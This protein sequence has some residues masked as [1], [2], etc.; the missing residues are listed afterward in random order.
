MFNVINGLRHE[1]VKRIFQSRNNVPYNLRQRPQFRTLY[2]QFACTVRFLGNPEK[3]LSS[4][5]LHP[6]LADYASGIFIRRLSLLALA[7]FWAMLI[8]F[9]VLLLVINIFINILVNIQV[10][11]LP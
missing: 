10:L 4:G 3:Q 9:F 7:L 5:K 8:L 1:I 11:L 2:M 6:V